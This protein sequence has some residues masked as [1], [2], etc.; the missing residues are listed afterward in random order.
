MTNLPMKSTEAP[1][2][3]S[4]WDDCPPFYFDCRAINKPRRDILSRY[5]PGIR[6]HELP[7]LLEDFNGYIVP[8][9]ELEL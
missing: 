4:F 5:E 7:Q 2:I 8:Y 3:R 6:G 1:R 9:G